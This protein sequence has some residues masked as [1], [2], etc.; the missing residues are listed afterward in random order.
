MKNLLLK[1][2]AAL[3]VLHSNLHAQGL[4]GGDPCPDPDLSMQRASNG[5][6]LV[7]WHA[8]AGTTQLYWAPL[9]GDAATWL[10]VNGTTPLPGDYWQAEFAANPARAF[11]KV[12]SAATPVPPPNFTLVM[13]GDHF[14][15]EWDST[16]D[17]SG[18]VVYV[19]LSPDTGPG[20][21]LQRLPL[22]LANALDITG[23][24]A[25]Q[26]YYITIAAKNPA[27]EGA[28]AQVVS[29]VYGPKGIFS[30]RAVWSFPQ[31]GCSDCEAHTVEAEGAVIQL[32][33]PGLPG[34]TPLQAVADEEGQF[35]IPLVPPGTWYIIWQANGQAG[36]L[37]DPVE[38]TVN[39]VVRSPLVLPSGPLPPP[40]ATTL[41][42]TLTLSTGDAPRIDLEEF[43]VHAKAQ[44]RANFADGS[45]RTVIPDRRGAWAL[46][47]ITGGFPVVLTATYQGLVKVTTL[48]AP[49]QELTPLNI[50]FTEVLPKL[51]RLTVWQNGVEVMQI[52]P[53][54][55][56]TFL[57][58]VD[59][60][61]QLPESPR[62]I[63]EVDGK[64]ML[65]T[66]SAPVFNFGNDDP[67][68]GGPDPGS[69]GEGTFIRIHFIPSQYT[70]ADLGPFSIA[71]SPVLVS[72]PGVGCWSG[73]VGT[74]NPAAPLDISE[75]NPATVTVTHTGFF[76]PSATN[77]TLSSNGRTYFELPLDPVTVPPYLVRV[78]KPGYMRFLWPFEFQLPK[79]GTYCVVPAMTW[80]LAQTGGLLVINH[81]GGAT[82]NLPYGGLLT[83]SNTQWFGSIIVRMTTWNP[84]DWTP[85]PPNA[86]IRGPGLRNGVVPYGCVWFDITTDT[87]I[88]LTP[89]ASASLTL[90]T[91][92]GLTAADYPCQHQVES[93]GYFERWGFPNYKATKIATGRYNVNL[94]TKGLFTI[95]VDAP[96]LEIVFEADRSLNYPFDV[97]LNRS[98]FPVTI[99]GACQNNFGHL[100]QMSGQV[101]GRSLYAQVLDERH[102]PGIYYANPAA[103]SF[104]LPVPSQRKP[105]ITYAFDF[106]TSPPPA[107]LPAIAPAWVRLSLGT[108]VGN[109][110]TL[111]ADT[112]VTAINGVNHFL[113]RMTNTAADTAVYYQ[114]IKAPATLA[115][116]RS[117]N[118]F[119]ATFG[120][121]ISGVAL[122]N[123]STCY[124]YNLG[125]LGF[126]RAQT[127]RI[128]PSGI[129]GQPDVAFAVT[130]YPTL[131]DARCR[132]SPIATVC[133]DNV[134]RTDLNQT[135]PSRYTRFYVYGGNGNLLDCANLDGGGLK[136][137][138]NLCIV[139]HGG[140]RYAS[141]ATLSDTTNFGSRFLPF[142]L[143]S[144]TW[145]PKYGVQK[146]ELA[147]MNAAVLK[148]A[149]NAIITDLITGWYGNPN[150]LA[151]FAVWNNYNGPYIP[152]VPA[153]TGWSLNQPIYKDVFKQSCRVCHISR[154]TTAPFQ[155]D[156]LTKLANVSYGYG[157]ACS[158]LSMPHSQRTWAV[159]WGS[160]GINGLSMNTPV[161]DQPA[162]L[163]SPLG[164]SFKCR[165]PP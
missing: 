68:G 61:D 162:L 14:R 26:T 104:S 99:T 117:F 145:H 110:K 93:T 58:E 78:D 66:G 19:G 157:S 109:L 82:L 44:L 94:G 114:K 102:A 34:G 121:S 119:P 38:M 3:A 77:T 148:T 130:N 33:S 54:V 16:C 1:L 151:S 133:M 125:D 138:P 10:P 88:S 41:L 137:V 43:G 4:P 30:G 80:N 42:G 91:D 18:Y 57:P 140:N 47:E 165:P 69:L 95:G 62:W 28:P 142:D 84:L 35:R 136:C 90:P 123:Y 6:L 13:T 71:V 101:S 160:R 105:N 100:Y 124:Y 128:L 120:G 135:T 147:A 154:D 64:K 150:P 73:M 86:E 163:V 107:V 22:P 106:L 11:F 152:T 85:L 59:N 37:P 48:P 49:P 23:L 17:A 153:A 76:N 29:G 12:E 46:P 51:H 89:V 111:P 39:G 5:H 8:A 141:P 83:P 65:A 36:F 55:P 74:W 118:G 50:Q 164:S 81:P 21:Y 92:P 70:A 25:G 112:T 75:A 45:S 87:G 20:N 52:A 161:P 129:D 103:A 40:P 15:L 139:C 31:T 158:G 60:P 98:I 127:M 122:E 9:L 56:V 156:S 97:R 113:G 155:F 146:P 79:E 132:R 144:Y 72:L 32:T 131:E 143:E 96:L 115:L 149:P 63:V 134:L 24:T 2:L 159:F 126:A 67:A 108:R 116:W 7:K 53:G 27:G